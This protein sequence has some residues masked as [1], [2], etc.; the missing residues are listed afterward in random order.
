MSDT[1]A[2]EENSF[3]WLDMIVVGAVLYFAWRAGPLLDY[4]GQ[5]LMTNSFWDRADDLMTYVIAFIADF[6]KPALTLLSALAV[7]S[8]F[9]APS[10]GVGGG[11]TV[12]F[13]GLGVWGW[14][15]GEEFAKAVARNMACE[16][17]SFLGLGCGMNAP[18][19]GFMG[20]G[21]L[22]M[23]LVVVFALTVLAGI[24]ERLSTTKAG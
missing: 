6:S 18:A 14:W 8:L 7:A 5:P 23:L 1:K 9:V 12:M 22:T 2:S 20:F 15:L 3:S 10:R 19:L 24:G 11:T 16:R 21:A 17:D 4:W 13:I